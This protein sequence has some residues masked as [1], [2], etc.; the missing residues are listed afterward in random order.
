MIFNPP[1]D[2]FWSRTYKAFL[3]Y[4]RQ[5]EMFCRSKVTSAETGWI[6][7][8]RE[9]TSGRKIFRLSLYDYPSFDEVH[10][11]FTL[12]DDHV[13]EGGISF[14]F[15]DECGYPVRQFYNYLG[16]DSSYSI[17][18]RRIYEEDPEHSRTTG[19]G[20]DFPIQKYIG[21]AELFFSH[22][23]DEN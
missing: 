2:T 11:S 21:F 19:P 9:M 20:H 23:L 10:M 17:A 22:A 15:P 18:W 1:V 13:D 8:V 14:I 16:E 4:T 5:Q 3:P 6:C 7:D 12:T